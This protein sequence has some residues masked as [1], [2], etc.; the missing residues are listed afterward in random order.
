MI[1]SNGLGK[2]YGR[3]DAM[4][5]LGKFTLA[6]MFV[7]VIGCEDSPLGPISMS[8]RATEFMKNF[9]RNIGAVEVFDHAKDWFLSLGAP[10]TPINEE[11]ADPENYVLTGSDAESFMQQVAFTTNPT[12]IYNLNDRHFFYG[13]LNDVNGYDACAPIVS[14]YNYQTIEGPT[15]A[16]LSGASTQWQ[17]RDVS[18]GAGLLPLAHLEGDVGSKFDAPA[19]ITFKTEVGKLKM[20]YQPDP[21]NRTGIIQL[22]SVNDQDEL[23]QDA[24]YQVL[25]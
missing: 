17:N 15:M 4:N 18:A 11:E 21:A 16:A 20:D 24:K 19:N 22:K 1:N 23:L 2:S 12:P 25:Y 14:E 13:A 6:S 7:P 9:A 3:R 8:G 5:L 10:N